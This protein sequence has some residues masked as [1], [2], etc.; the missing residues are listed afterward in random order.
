MKWEDLDEVKKGNVGERVVDEYLKK[1]EFSIYSTTTDKPHP[2]DRFVAKSKTDFFIAEVKTKAKMNYWNATG[3]NIKHYNEYKIVEKVTGVRIFIFFV[4]D[5][6][7]MVYGNWLSDLEKE[8][9]YRGHKFPNTTIVNNGDV[10]LFSRNNMKN[11][12]PVSDEVCCEI[13]QWS[14]NTRRGVDTKTGEKKILN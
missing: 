2:F 12:C 14:K 5:A 13:K 3:F 4:D 1:L 7:K 11:I 6:E 10:I 8:V 9:T